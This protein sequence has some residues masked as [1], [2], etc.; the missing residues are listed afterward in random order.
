MKP[1]ALSSLRHAARRRAAEDRFARSSDDFREES[2]MTAKL[3][4]SPRTNPAPRPSNAPCWQ[5]SRGHRARRHQLGTGVNALY[6]SLGAAFRAN[7]LIC[8]WVGRREGRLVAGGPLGRA[9]RIGEARCGAAGL[10]AAFAGSDLAP[11]RSDRRSRS[12]PRTPATGCAVA[13][14]INLLCALE[15]AARQR[16]LAARHEHIAAAERPDLAHQIARGGISRA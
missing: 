5:A 2:I 12:S 13:R 3:I 4:R 10:R 1:D 11:S 9:E 7:K 6:E 14:A 15:R 8:A 16:R